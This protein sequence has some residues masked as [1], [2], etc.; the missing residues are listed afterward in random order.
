MSNGAGPVRYVLYSHYGYSEKEDFSAYQRGDKVEALEGVRRILSRCRSLGELLTTPGHEGLLVLFLATGYERFLQ[1]LAKPKPENIEDL[2]DRDDPDSEPLRYVQEV[3][4]HLRS[5]LKSEGLYHR[6]RILTCFELNVILGRVNTIFAGKFH[7]YFIGEPGGMRYDSPKIVEAILRLRLLGNGI[8][9]LRIDHDVLFTGEETGE[10]RLF[11][12]I[13]CSIL[14]Y[15]LRL[16]EPTVSTFLFSASYDFQAL[17][18]REHSFDAWS[19]AFATRLYPALIA[20]I[21][22]INSIAGLSQNEQRAAWNKYVQSHVDDD[23]ARQFYGLKRGVSVSGIEP[24]GIEGLTSIGAHPLFSVIS[25]ALLCLSEGAILDLPPFSNMG[26]NV[27]WIDDHLKYSL[28]R[29]MNHFTSGD[30]LELRQPGMSDARLDVV[31]T[32]GR[33]VVDNLPSYVCGTYLPNVL[34]GTIMDAWIN[35]DSILKS[36]ITKLST[37][38]ER[39]RWRHARETQQDA[40]LPGAMLEALRVGTFHPDSEEKLKDVLKNLAIERIEEVRQLWAKLRSDS[41][42]TFAS[43]WAAGEINRVFPQAYFQNC[44]DYLWQGIAPGRSIDASIER[45]TDLSTEM[46]LSVTHL[47]GDTITYVHWTLEW[48][49]FVQIVRS[50]KQGDFVGDLSWGTKKT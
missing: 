38:A 18:Q 7:K 45:L 22:Q 28:H 6:V 21:E 47:I 14:A 30:Q 3:A 42:G 4:N 20:D 25:G 49:T 37:Q 41:H 27:M 44:K 5:K 23:L 11:K 12:A 2:V 9:V 33:Q 26:F 39:R 1:A 48:P 15:Q 19:R 35:R 36:R 8:P 17:K 46:A 29:A 31:V 16:E 13:A 24:D 34:W 40:A 32:K 43:Y 50:V 10:L